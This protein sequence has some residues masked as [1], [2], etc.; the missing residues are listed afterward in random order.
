MRKSRFSQNAL[1]VPFVNTEGS[2]WVPAYGVMTIESWKL[3]RETD[4]GISKLRAS[5]RRCTE[6]DEK[7]QNH[8]KVLFNGQSPVRPG[9][10]GFG[11]MSVPAVARIGRLLDESI[12][13][14]YVSVGPARDTWDLWWGG[15]THTLLSVGNRDVAVADTELIPLGFVST[16]TSPGLWV[17][18]EAANGAT[19]TDGYVLGVAKLVN[20]DDSDASSL[21][22]VEAMS[23]DG[24][25][26]T[27]MQ[28]EYVHGGGTVTADQIG[29]VKMVSGKWALDVQY[30]E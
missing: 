23:N 18:T 28:V 17:K 8:S 27:T 11:T 3:E 22:F 2:E 4:T 9:G 25:T 7:E 12:P 1:P 29:Q 5:I 20:R 24:A 14:D 19:T 26:E 30:C 13:V 10:R 21:A 16:H 6:A 15:G